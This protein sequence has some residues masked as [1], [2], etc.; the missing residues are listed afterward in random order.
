[1][2]NFKSKFLIHTGIRN[3]NIL[4]YECQLREPKLRGTYDKDE[5]SLWCA[6]SGIQKSW[7]NIENS[8]LFN[9]HYPMQG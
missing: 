4:K 9:Q 2:P 8:G 6:E 3:Y 7:V 5:V 1:M